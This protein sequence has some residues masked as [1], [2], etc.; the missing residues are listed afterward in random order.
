M[1]KIRSYISLILL[2]VML[3][4]LIEKVSHQL[5]HGDENHCGNKDLHFCTKEHS[6]KICDYV[7]SSSDVPIIYQHEIKANTIFVSFDFQ[8]VTPNLPSLPNLSYSLRAP[9]IC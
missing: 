9:P 4:P 3:F 8:F 6:C 1:Q 2:A 7:F 5:E